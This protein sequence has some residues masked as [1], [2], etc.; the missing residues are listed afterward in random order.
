MFAEIQC[1]NEN[2]YFRV[3]DCQNFWK[4][5]FLPNSIDS[6]PNQLTIAVIVVAD[7][8][9]VVTLTFLSQT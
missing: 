5:V 6:S 1:N 3:F 7:V 9:A 2:F 8:V 4:K